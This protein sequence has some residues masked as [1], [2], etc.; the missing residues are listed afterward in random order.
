[1]FFPLLQ[2]LSVISTEAAHSFTVSSA[3]ERPPHFAFAVALA[4]LVVVVAL[5]FLV[6]IPEG[7]LLLY[8][9]LLLPSPFFLHKTKRLHLRP[10]AKRNRKLASQALT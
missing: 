8:L 4:C 6:V 7:D 1:L 10:S 2:K 3:A 5:A 9:S